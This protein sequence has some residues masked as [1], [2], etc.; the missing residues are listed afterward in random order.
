M[1]L[2]NSLS[3][4][5]ILS[6]LVGSSSAAFSGRKALAPGPDAAAPPLPDDFGFTPLDSKDP[7]VV[8][9][10]RFAIDEHNKESN[11]ALVF[12]AVLEA[13]IPSTA[14]ANGGTNFQ[15]VILATNGNDLNTYF[16]DV[17]VA[18]NDVKKLTSFTLG[19]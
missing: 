4:L 15:L 14:T 9:L 18:Q 1:A 19:Q 11:G 8:D 13:I 12:N 5:V 2:I 7:K 17:L 3:F 10:A 6:L 16:S